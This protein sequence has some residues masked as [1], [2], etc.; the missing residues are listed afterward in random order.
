MQPLAASSAAPGQLRWPDAL[1][2]ESS[3]WQESEV[4]A[5]VAG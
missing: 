2:Q 4:I 3:Y 1:P 5:L